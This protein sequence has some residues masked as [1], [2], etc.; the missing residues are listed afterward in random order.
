MSNPTVVL[1]L[2]LGWGFDNS[3]EHLEQ[4]PTITVTYVQVPFVLATFVHFRNFSAVT[5]YTVLYS[6]KQYYTGLYRT[7][8][9]YTVPFR[10]IQDYT[11]HTSLHRIIC[12]PTGLYRTV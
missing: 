9:D 3:W 5:D 2:R 12:D 4:I 8:H 10:T 7:I 6:T 11:G 1:R